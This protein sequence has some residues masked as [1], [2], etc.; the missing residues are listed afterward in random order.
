MPRGYL[1]LL[2]AFFVVMFGTFA[3]P[4]HKSKFGTMAAWNM[5]GR[6]RSQLVEMGLLPAVDWSFG[7]NI[8]FPLC[9]GFV[10]ESTH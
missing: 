9:Q 3:R 2:E 8:A 6:I 1:G 5:S 4:T 10:S 7:L